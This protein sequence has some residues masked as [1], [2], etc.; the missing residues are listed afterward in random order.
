M[1][2]PELIAYIQKNAATF[3]RPTIVQALITAGWQLPDINAAFNELE[4]P[5]A[6][7]TVE[8][9]ARNPDTKFLAEM[10][11][12]RKEAETAVLPSVSAG[13]TTSAYRQSTPVTDTKG[14]AGMLIR[15]GLVKT[16]SQANIAMIV[17][18]VCMLGITAWLLLPSFL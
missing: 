10:E 18:I 16:E 4:H 8:G 2:P 1:A 9:L 6:P 13:Q 12:H 11:R 5:N 3:D 17:F 14:I 7:T 15:M